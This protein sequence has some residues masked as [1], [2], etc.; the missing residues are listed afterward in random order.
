MVLLDLKSRDVDAI[1]AVVRRLDAVDRVLLLAGGPAEYDRIR[2]AGKEF[3][4]VAR[5][6]KRSDVGRWIDRNDA[7]IVAIHGNPDFMD[8]ARIR[9]VHDAGKKVWL[10]AFD[11]TWHQEFF[12]GGGVAEELFERG[13]DIIHTNVPADA[14]RVRDSK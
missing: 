4:I 2:A 13:A 9:R 8:A 12:G 3:W 1:A 5:A 11:A 10:N 14:A 7:R 6:R